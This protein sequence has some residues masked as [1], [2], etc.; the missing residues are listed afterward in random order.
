[1]KMEKNTKKRKKIFVVAAASAVCALMLG[2]FAWE[3]YKDSKENK[4]GNAIVDGN[5]KVVE[6]FPDP[7]MPLDKVV[8]KEVGIMNQSAK[9][10]FI[11]TSFEEMM[12]NLKNTGK[13]A[14][15]TSL[16]VE[17]GLNSYH[18]PVSN[19]D[20]IP[21]ITDVN[22]NY[23][24]AKMG[25]VGALDSWY[26][27]PE[28]MLPDLPADVVVLVKSTSK[29]IIQPDGVTTKKAFTTEYQAFRK[30]K[31]ANISIGEVASNMVAKLTGTT[32]DVAIKV[33]GDFKQI[34]DNN[35][36][37]T[38]ITGFTF[39][40]IEYPFYDGYDT[41][42]LANWATTDEHGT[43]TAK[44]PGTITTPGKSAA[45]LNVELTYSTADIN[46]T[47]PT[48]NKW[49]FN[50][51]DGYFYYIGLVGSGDTTPLLL[52]SVKLDSATAGSEYAYLD[53]SLW[54]DAEGMFPNVN[55]L[56]NEWGLPTGPL[57]TALEN[58]VP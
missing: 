46:N 36:N 3:V 33:E 1:M 13:D 17:N 48:A 56:A 11:R 35:D 57:R 50:K 12:K 4:F 20:A 47:T 51:D 7:T 6:E 55:A 26:V 39:G 34:V 25:T 30:M 41:P 10:V 2:T 52:K 19:P 9:E 18:M 42:K 21:L 53:Y 38:A 16:Y 15:T 5:I 44:H 28:S 32:T 27:A 29:D 40:K 8:K 54:I 23:D 45:D 14:P 58:L 22:I 49:F 24:L 31:L 37:P 43:G